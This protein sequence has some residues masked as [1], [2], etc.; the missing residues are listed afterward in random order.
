[1]VEVPVA[2]DD[3]LEAVGRDRQP[4]QVADQPVRGDAGVEEQPPLPPARPH[5]DHRREAVLGAQEVDGLATLG[6]AGGDD[7]D[8][9]RGSGRAP[10]PDQPLVGHQHVRRVVDDR[11]HM[12]AVNLFE[13]DLLHSPNVAS[14]HAWHRTFV[15]EPS[16]TGSIWYAVASFG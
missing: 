5:L 15:S 6:Q 14:V 16:Q 9:A 7:R 11:C 10:P 4:V 13:G 8:R 3:R 1:M 2:Q 12:D